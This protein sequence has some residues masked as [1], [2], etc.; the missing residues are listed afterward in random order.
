MVSCA[1]TTAT[2]ANTHPAVA[3]SRPSASDPAAGWPSSTQTTMIS[4]P[5][6]VQAPSASAR[7]AA[8]GAWRPTAVAPSSSARP[9][10]SSP[11]VCLITR[12]M[13]ISAQPIAAMSPARQAMM[14]P[15][16]EEYAAP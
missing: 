9:A 6:T 10:S 12:K 5:R 2:P 16:E 1:L 4:K 14:A 3:T 8:S 13:L 15:S 11:R 7:P